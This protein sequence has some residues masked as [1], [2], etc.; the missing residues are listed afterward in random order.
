MGDM[1][2]MLCLP[3]GVC[4]SASPRALRTFS[5]VTAPCAQNLKPINTNSQDINWTSS[6]TCS[7]ESIS[8]DTTCSK[9][10][11]AKALLPARR[12]RLKPGVFHRNCTLDHVTCDAWVLGRKRD[13]MFPPIKGFLKT[14]SGAFLLLE[15]RVCLRRRLRFMERAFAIQ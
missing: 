8:S 4:R 15:R 2:G 1:T 11:S 13:P 7:P 3:L 12:V 9:V 10:Y 14:S 6:S 5:C